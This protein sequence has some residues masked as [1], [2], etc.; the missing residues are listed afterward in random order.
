MIEDGDPFGGKGLGKHDKPGKGKGKKGG[1]GNGTDTTNQNDSMY[2][3]QILGTIKKSYNFTDAW[4][5][6]SNFGYRDVLKAYDIIKTGM[7]NASD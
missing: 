4:G 6:R 5:G 1:K 2:V 3:D 7:S